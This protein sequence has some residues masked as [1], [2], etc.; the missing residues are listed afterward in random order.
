MDRSTLNPCADFLLNMVRAN[1]DD[2]S[3]HVVGEAIDEEW[4]GRASRSWPCAGETATDDETL[5]WLHARVPCIEPDNCNG[6]A[7]WDMAAAGFSSDERAT[8]FSSL[9]RIG[10]I[11]GFRV[12][13]HGGGQSVGG[14]S[15][16]VVTVTFDMALHLAKTP[17]PEPT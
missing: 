15:P 11:L 14:P 4:R 2:L 10:D 17:T 9:L 3:V 5:A 12:H 6:S 7:S 13:G 16:A 8:M 1:G